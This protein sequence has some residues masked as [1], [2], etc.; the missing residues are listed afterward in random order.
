MTSENTLGPLPFEAYEPLCTFCCYQ[1]SN[2]MVQNGAH[3]EKHL[4][5]EILCLLAFHP[6]TLTREL[7]MPRQELNCTGPTLLTCHYTHGD[8]VKPKSQPCK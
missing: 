5:K 2:H 8:K 6:F 3:S 7:N 4:I 1:H